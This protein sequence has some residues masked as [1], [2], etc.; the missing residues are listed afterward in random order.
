MI[1]CY[2]SIWILEVWGLLE[3]LDDKVSAKMQIE[4]VSLISKHFHTKFK[5]LN[6]PFLPLPRLSNVDF[7]Q[8][9]LFEKKSKINDEISSLSRS[10]LFKVFPRQLNF[11]LDV[12]EEPAKIDSIE[13]SFSFSCFFFNNLEHASNEHT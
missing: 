9:K 8:L 6:T 10:S 11:F 12:L 3:D 2:R 1:K 13:S 5:H 7:W 4:N